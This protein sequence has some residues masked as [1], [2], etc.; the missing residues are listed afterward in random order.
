M[1]INRRKIA[2]ILG[3][4]VIVTGAIWFGMRSAVVFWDIASPMPGPWMEVHLTDG[5]IFYGKIDGVAMGVVRLSHVSGLERYVPATGAI[6][7]GTL[8]TGAS[9]NYFIG[10]QVSDSAREKYIVDRKPGPL[11]LNRSAI[12]FWG[13]VD[14][15]AEV[16]K[17]LK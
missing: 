16:A 8:E 4:L 11:Y 3:V 12:V 17:Y 5:S 7:G 2:L 14:P 9:A 10:G 15:Q 1:Y 13:P 6:G